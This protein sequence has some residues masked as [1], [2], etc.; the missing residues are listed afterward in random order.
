MCFEPLPCPHTSP[1]DLHCATR[2]AAWQAQASFESCVDGVHLVSQLARNRLLS[3][4]G[5]NVPNNV[6]VAATLVSDAAWRDIPPFC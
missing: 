4:S 1:Y 3:R 6:Y 2:T 5:K